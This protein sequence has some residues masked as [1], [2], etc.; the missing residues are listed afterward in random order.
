MIT[1]NERHL[2]VFTYFKWGERPSVCFYDIEM[3]R[4]VGIAEG[5]CALMGC[6]P[7]EDAYG[8]FRMTF[9]RNALFGQKVVHTAGDFEKSYNFAVG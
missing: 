9:Y 8:V 5:C 1:V 6:K 3:Q 2:V 4:E 7:T